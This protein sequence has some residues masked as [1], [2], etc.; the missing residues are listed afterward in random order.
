[1]S[2][3]LIIASH[4]IHVMRDLR[5]ILREICDYDIYS[6]LDFP[7]FQL[8]KFEGEELS[9]Q[10]KVS[11]EAIEAAKTL[12]RLAISEKTK[13]L[14]P[15]LNK[16]LSFLFT[17]SPSS[18]LVRRFYQD[19]EL[20]SID[21]RFAYL[22]C[23]MSLAAPNGDIIKSVHVSCEGSVSPNERGGNGFG[24]DSIFIK[25]GYDKTFAQLNE[26]TK[27][28][29]SPHRKALDKLLLPLEKMAR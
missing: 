20:L 17:S 12:N 22:E 3:D 25:N 4:H 19:I 21:Q 8:S 13:L 23:Y 29:I 5:G 15:S 6:L 7:S 9:T 27:N 1:M 18:T 2:M 26:G 10:E 14:I 24:A 11:R 28:K 16:D